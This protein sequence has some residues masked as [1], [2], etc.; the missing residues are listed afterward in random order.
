MR[1][2]RLNFSCLVFRDY[3]HCKCTRIGSVG[4][5]CTLSRLVFTVA[6]MFGLLTPTVHY[7]A[8]VN[9]K[10]T[11]TSNKDLGCRLVNLPSSY[12]AGDPTPA[13]RSGSVALLCTLPSVLSSLARPWAVSPPALAAAVSARPNCPFLDAYNG[14]ECACACGGSNFFS[15]LVLG[16]NTLTSAPLASCSGLTVSYSTALMNM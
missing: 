16:P 11:V 1:T 12:G 6:F 8:K 10:L 5:T 14:P 2:S 7:S 13:S 3:Q 4:S 15:V 9:H